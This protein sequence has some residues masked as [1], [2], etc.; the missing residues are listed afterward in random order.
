MTARIPLAIGLLTAM[1]AFGASAAHA[2]LSQEVTAG[3]AV[4]KRVDAGTATCKT[5][6]TNDFEHL[7]EYVMERMVGSHAA[8]QAMN[9]HMEQTIGAENADRMHQALGRRYAGCSTSGWA[10]GPGMMS[11][12]GGMMGG[13][14]GDSRGLGAMMGSGYAWMRNGAW[15]HMTRNDWRHAGGYMMGNGWMIG[16]VSGG[17]SSGAVVG[18]ALGAFLVLAIVALGLFRRT[19]RHPP[20][21]PTPAQ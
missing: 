2:S 15:L 10:N 5:L 12:S 11:G 9:A 1:L 13:G 14:Y 19:R 18:L 16:T 4:A 7:G 3:K 20:S 21:T 8:H 6:S 17:P